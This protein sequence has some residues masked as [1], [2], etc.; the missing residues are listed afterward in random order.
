MKKIMMKIINVLLLTGLVLVSC[1]KP[2]KKENIEKTAE[3]AKT[4]F[5]LIIDTFN[6]DNKVLEM[7]TF[8]VNNYNPLY[9]GKLTDSI[10]IT[11]H[12]RVSPPAQLSEKIKNL[13][14]PPEEPKSAFYFDLYKEYFRYGSFDMFPNW[15]SA[16]LKIAFDTTQKVTYLN[17]LPKNYKDYYY[18]AFPLYIQNLSKD[19]VMVGYGKWLDLILEAKDK[20][21]NWQEI[22]PRTAY[23]L[24][25]SLAKIILSPNEIVLTAIP[26][27]KGDYKTKLRLKIGNNYSEEFNGEINYSQ[28]EKGN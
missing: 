12:L 18:H 1:T 19:T 9:F 25:S 10:F 14:N 8:T 16:K 24:N 15:D 4:E 13:K 22:Q 11:Y 17:F 28:I 7:D 23:Y 20:E 27:Y 5:P 26:I 6:I 3:N 2:V 21:N